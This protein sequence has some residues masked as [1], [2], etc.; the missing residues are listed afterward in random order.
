[1]N[2]PQI[3]Q[4]DLIAQT[5]AQTM[6]GPLSFDQW[7]PEYQSEILEAADAV[8]EAT[9]GISADN[10]GFHLALARAVARGLDGGRDTDAWSPDYAD[11]MG[12]VAD[13]LIA[14]L[15]GDHV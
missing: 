3:A 9:A 10:A 11:E 1:M 7:A 6:N 5:I 8:V 4:R 13:A 15:G 2:T 12:A 14:M